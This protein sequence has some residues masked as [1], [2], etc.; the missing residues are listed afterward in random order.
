VIGAR[1]FLLSDVFSLEDS[2]FGRLVAVVDALKI[3]SIYPIAIDSVYL[4][5]YQ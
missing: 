5:N 1:K 3:P 2:E 4:S